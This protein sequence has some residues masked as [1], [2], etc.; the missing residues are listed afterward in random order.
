M[1]SGLSALRRRG[2]V[3][4]EG[5][6]AVG[7]ATSF[8]AVFAAS[9]CC[10]LPAALAVAGV[11]AGLSSTFSALVPLHWPLTI[12]AFA[13]V[14]FGWFSYARRRKLCV[15]DGTCTR[16][17]P[18]RATLVMLLVATAMVVV[19]AVWP[20]IEAPLTDAIGAA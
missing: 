7:A 16:S 18:S 9:A 14:A 3:K 13:A 1:L 11:G 20:F 10:V 8:S 2:R 4:E 19:S 5:V 15:V 12:V 17:P 6:A